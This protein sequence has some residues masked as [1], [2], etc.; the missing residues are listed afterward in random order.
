M[1]ALLDAWAFHWLSHTREAVQGNR[2]FR[3]IEI[4]AKALVQRPE[5]RVLGKQGGT[6]RGAKRI[7]ELGD[8]GLCGC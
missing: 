8:A 6:M 2:L 1:I 3:C 4:A 7:K 5:H